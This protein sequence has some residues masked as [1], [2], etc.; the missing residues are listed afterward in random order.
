MNINYH[1]I[2]IPLISAFTGWFTTWIAIKMLFHPRKP[3]R[4]LGLKIQGVFP[5]NQEQIADKLGDVVH[6]ELLSFNEIEQ[7][8]SN[9]QNFQKLKP[10]LEKHID[11][12]L[13]TRMPDIFPILSMFIGE[14]TIKQLK[15]AFLTEL[16]A[17]FP[18]LMKSYMNKL[19]NELDLKK[20][21]REKVAGFSG[22]KLEDMLN[23]IT[24]KEFRFL[25]VVGA[26]FGFL[27]GLIQLLIT[28]TGK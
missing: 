20:I 28:L 22:D 19:E 1:W 24:K 27:I 23:K 10:E 16:E 14:K 17:L 4:F 26:V 11:H 13:R 12:F 21:V 6:D 18:V 8:V 15:A 2:L 9:P 7:K 25:E 3:I 5:K